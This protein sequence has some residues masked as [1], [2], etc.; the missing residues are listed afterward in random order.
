MQKILAL[1]LFLLLAH[2]YCLTDDSTVATRRILPEDVA[3][4]SV[5]MWRMDANKFAVHWT[6]TEAGAKK[7]VAFQDANEGK[8][9]RMAAGRFE[10]VPGLIME[11]RPM[12]PH[13]TNYAQWK[14]GWLQ[15]RTDKYYGL[16]ETNAKLLAA[17]L[18]GERGVMSVAP[19]VSDLGAGWSEKRV[20]YAVDPVDQPA[21][22]VNDSASQD[23]E[24][25]D[26]LLAQVKAEMVRV[27]V[28]GM[29]YFGYGFG[30]MVVGKGRYDLYLSRFPDVNSLEKEWSKYAQQAGTHTEPGVGEAAIWLPRSAS[31]HDYRLVVRKV[32][33]L[34]RLECTSKQE[35][36]KLVQ[37][38]KATVDKAIGAGGATRR[39]TTPT[40]KPLLKVD[41]GHYVSD[42]NN[43]HPKRYEIAPASG[44]LLDATGYSFKPTLATQGLPV[45]SVEIIQ[46]GTA[47]EGAAERRYRLPVTPSETRH[48]LT[49]TTLQPYPGSPPFAGFHGGERW[50]V[51]IMLAATNQSV[52]PFAGWSGVIEVKT[53]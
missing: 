24:N 21:E 2:Q 49:S 7:M 36:E 45:D 42:Y 22:T 13:V 51:F 3:P 33:Y 37:L 39:S 11:F 40:P 30:N 31:D 47:K 38:A 9:V 18:K 6:Y 10:T 4:G 25:R 34:L 27:G 43:V 41:D 53:D 1:T 50:F 44:I 28:D 16:D 5:R 46:Y 19:D 35:E 15:H 52:K 8:K 26:R 48:D 14:E 32:S 17:G 12:P 20:V 29:G 23:P